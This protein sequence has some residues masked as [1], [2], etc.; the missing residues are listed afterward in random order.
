MNRGGLVAVVAV[1]T[2]L[3]P[4]GAAAKRPAPVN[5]S[6]PA[7]SGA[8]VQGSMLHGTNGTWTNNPTAYAYQWQRCN[9]G[10]ANCIAISGATTSGYAPGPADFGDT[11]R[12]AVTASNAGGTSA[13]ATST[14]T[15]VVTAPAG[16]SANAYQLNAGHTGATPDGVWAGAAKRWSVNLGASISYPLIVGNDVFVTAGDNN[17]S[18]SR[19]YALDANT[20]A[21]KWGPVEVGGGNPWSG[22]A[23]DGGRIF[24][25]NEHG[26]ME[27]FDATSG[28]LKWA[29][30]LPN[31]YL[32][33]SP[34][35]A[36]GGLVYTG[37][38]GSGGTVYAVDESTG[39]VVWT[40][41]V[42][43]GDNSS[44]AVSSGGVYVSYA[45]GQ[46]YD[47][48]PG[49]GALLWH[50]NTSCEGGGGKTPVLA[51][52]RLYVRDF[53]FPGIFD[54]STGSLLRTFAS[55]GA[56]PAVS[57][58]AVYHQQGGTLSASGVTPGS[59]TTWSFTGDGTL[60]SA[61]LV[62]GGDVF[63]AGTSGNVYALSAATGGIVWS[64]NAGSGVAAPDE[65]NLSQPLTGLAVS[66]G[67][68]VVPAGDTLVAI[69]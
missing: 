34:P 68:L 35:T 2:L 18:G 15:A 42:M 24:T 22:L 20:G 32:F 1:A 29:V 12:V 57:S 44:P 33:S 7:I 16:T 37:G 14:Q 65:Q 41:S 43:N 48:A 67:L 6:V 4:G 59:P 58:S 9:S 19:L 47:F 8:A 63:V 54:A 30:Q 64:A 61:P 69:R 27:A 55:T 45:C 31:Q 21:V 36:A 11:L 17:S 62:A 52:G 51:N 46:T 53:Q 50:V 56:A 28:A 3:L 39:A 38:A 13:A 60:S 26:T 10:G 5:T 40:S 66:G 25:V 23:Y 49:S